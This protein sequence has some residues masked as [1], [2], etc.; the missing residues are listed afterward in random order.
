MVL[1]CEGCHERPGHSLTSASAT[2]AG[3]ECDVHG[4]LERPG[5]WSRDRLAPAASRLLHH[6][7]GRAV[8]RAALRHGAHLQPRDCSDVIG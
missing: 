7:V 6:R 3:A 5:E 1:T 8:L 2:P 4:C